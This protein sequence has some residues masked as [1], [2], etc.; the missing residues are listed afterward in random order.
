MTGESSGGRASSASGGNRRV[1]GKSKVTSLAA[2]AASVR[3]GQSVTFSGFGHGGHPMAFVRELIRQR[4]GDFTLNAIAECWPAEFL[5]GAGAVCA[6][7]MS[8]LMFE[9]LGRCRAISRAI[10]TGGIV[11]DDHSH[12]GLSLRLLAAG[13]GVPFLPIR[14]MAGTDLAKLQTRETPKYQRITSPFGQEQVGVV[15]ALPTDV[16]V[17]HVNKCDEQGNSI[18][19]GAVSAIDAQVRAAKRVIITTECLV[20]ADEIVAENQLSVVP[21]FLVDAVVHAPFGA[22]PTSM[23]KLYDEDADHMAHYYQAS[24]DEEALRSYHKEVIHSVRDEREYL[25]SLGSKRLFGLR[26]DPA[27]QVALKGEF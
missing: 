26:V 7:N 25:Q 5:V 4:R 22:H 8:N 13:W 6:I 27:F 24:R 18:V 19:Y 21:G 15:S 23:Y 14:S 17:V 9:G 12:L 1:N 16:A 3:D 2:A 20:S 11:V 10:E